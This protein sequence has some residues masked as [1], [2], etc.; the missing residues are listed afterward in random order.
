MHLWSVMTKNPRI[1]N[2]ETIVFLMQALRT[3]ESHMHKN[4]TGSLPYTRHKDQLK[5]G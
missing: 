5:M 3:L 2:R 4:E 1:Y